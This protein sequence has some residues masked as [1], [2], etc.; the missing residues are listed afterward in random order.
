M[1]RA[2]WSSSLGEAEASLPTRIRRD[3]IGASVQAVD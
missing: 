3:R 1:P 2:L